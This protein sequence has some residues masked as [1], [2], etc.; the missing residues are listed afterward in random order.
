MILI[1]KGLIRIMDKL[2]K[3]L[4]PEIE[5]RHQQLLTEARIDEELQVLSCIDIVRDYYYTYRRWNRH[6]YAETYNDLWNYRTKAAENLEQV[7]THHHQL[8]EAINRGGCIELQPF[9]R[10]FKK[11]V[12]QLE[13]KHE[14]KAS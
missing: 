11:K 3:A 10:E 12:S 1:N 5:H 9:L 4:L 7:D 8:L 2:K 14:Q 13:H 6:T